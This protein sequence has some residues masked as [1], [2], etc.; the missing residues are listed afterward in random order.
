MDRRSELTIG[1]LLIPFRLSMDFLI[2]FGAKYLVFFVV[3]GSLIVLTLIDKRE[4]RKFLF[5]TVIAGVTATI[6][7]QVASSVY[8]DP[9]PFT[10]G[11][12]ALIA[13]SIENGFPSD[14]T[15]LSFC[16]AALAFDFRRKIGLCLLL[17][18]ALV[19]ISRVLAGVHHPIDVIAGAAI[20]ILATWFA[21]WV[22]H[23][24]DSRK[25]ARS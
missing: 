6:L 19:G 18:S 10:Q 5:A 8:D 20:G 17:L 7:K 16:A 1:K 21:I 23:R 25:D 14:H 9:R 2:V 15:V 3:L 24:L 4:Q 22:V 13:H 11:V 12:H